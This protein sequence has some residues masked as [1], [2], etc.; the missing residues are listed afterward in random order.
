MCSYCQGANS[1]KKSQK[2]SENCKGLKIKPMKQQ[3][4]WSWSRQ[5]CSDPMWVRGEEAKW[6]RTRQIFRYKLPHT[7]LLFFKPQYS[8]Y[9]NKKF[10]L[11]QILHKS[12]YCPT[13]LPKAQ[14][15][16]SVDLKKKKR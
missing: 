11:V 12:H 16:V 13:N 9:S 1:E 14:C 2:K 15:N 3:L 6:N 5:I 4:S 8:Q 10:N 7:S